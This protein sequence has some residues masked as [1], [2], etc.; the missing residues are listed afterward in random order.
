MTSCATP[1]TAA[2]RFA[3]APPAHFLDVLGAIADADVARGNDL[4]RFVD[5]AKP[6]V[7]SLTDAQR[8]RLPAFLGMTD[9]AGS[10]QA[11]GQLWLFEE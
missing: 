6:L 9:H 1:P 10:A 5:T 8:R 3:A 4:R 7:N 11:S 2:Q